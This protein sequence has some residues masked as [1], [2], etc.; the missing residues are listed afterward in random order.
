MLATGF[1][2]G[3]LGIAGY[4]RIRKHR[5]GAA[6]HQ[7]LVEVTSATLH[8]L[9]HYHF[10]DD[11]GV[12]QQ[13]KGT[14]LARLGDFLASYS[15]I[16]YPSPASKERTQLA[17]ERN[18]LAG[19]RT[20][21]ACYRTIYAR[22]RTGLAFIRTGVAFL[23]LGLGL[24]QYFGISMLTIFDLLLI[25]AGSWMIAD[26]ALWYY[27]VRNEQAELPRCPVAW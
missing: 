9:E 5:M 27:P 11:T 16:L 12:K 14:M 21:A 26:G 8:F 2:F 15:T 4:L 24:I 13:T 7:T 20:V 6:R 18:V 25:A 1:V 10:I 23:S 3:I 19:Q 22:A 17:R